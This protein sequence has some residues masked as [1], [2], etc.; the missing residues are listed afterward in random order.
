VIAWAKSLGLPLRSSDEPPYPPGSGGGGGGG[1]PFFDLNDEMGVG[2]PG[3]ML[4]MMPPGMM[5]PH[6]AG[7]LGHMAGPIQWLHVGGQPPPW[8]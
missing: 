3:M 1:G 4:P 5:P 8:A 7:P 2:P 6:M